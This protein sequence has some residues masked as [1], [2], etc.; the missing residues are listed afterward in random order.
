LENAKHLKEIQDEEFKEKKEVII[1]KLNRFE[2]KRKE[3][4]KKRLIKIENKAFESKWHFKKLMERKENLNKADDDFKVAVL[5][6]QMERMKRSNFKDMT[7][8]LNRI[9]F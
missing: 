4:N 6:Q 3:I 5:N 2:T 1:E 9:N 7:S 8:N